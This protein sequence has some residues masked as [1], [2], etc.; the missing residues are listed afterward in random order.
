MTTIDVEPDRTA[1][2]VTEPHVRN[3]VAIIVSRFPRIDETFILREIN[4]LE[5]QGQPVVL[6]PLLR[7]A[8]SVVHEEA[9]PWVQRAMYLPLLSTAIVASNIRQLFRYPV[10]Y[11]RL[12][13]GLIF[14][15]IFNPGILLRTLAL[16]PKSV[17]LAWIFPRLGIKHIHAHFATH[18]TT[19]AYIVSKLTDVTYSFT[20]H[21]PDI[22]VH[23]LLLRKKITG[24]KF[25]RAVSTFNKAFM[26]GL[27]PLVAEDKVEVVHMG[28]NADV[29]SDAAAEAPRQKPRPQ[30][31]SVA[32]LAPSKGFPFLIDAIARLAKQGVDV[33]CRIVGDGPLRHVTER[34]I[35]QHGLESSVRLQGLLRQHEVARLMG[36]C[37]VFMLPSIIAENG[38]MDG[39]PVSLMEAMAAGRP[40]IASALSGIPELVDNEI[41]GLLVDATHPERIA[42]AI[43]RLV[44]DPELRDRMGRAGQRKVRE[45]FDIRRTTSSLMELFERHEEAA[46]EAPESLARLNWRELDVMALGIR[47]LRERRSS[48]IAEVTTTDGVKKRDVVVKQQKRVSADPTA[49]ISRARDEYEVLSRLREQLELSSLEATSDILYTVP[50]VIMFDRRNASLIMERASGI[51]LEALVRDAR[52]RNKPARLMGPLRRA[53]SW[54][55]QMED[56]TRR[57]EDGR[58]ILAHRLD[59]AIAELDRAAIRDGRIRRAHEAIGETIHSLAARLAEKPMV[60]VGHHGEFAPINVFI[61]DR[62]VEV[63]DFDRYRDGLPYEDA[64]YFIVR[65]QMYF[66]YPFVRHSIANLT[67]SF[68]NGYAGSAAAVDRDAL[69]LYS[70]ITGLELLTLHDDEDEVLKSWWHRRALRE[71]VTG[72]R[73]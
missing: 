67:E 68:L 38:N 28:V 26:L 2:D 12:L 73:P 36:E 11:L 35:A 39:I 46:M 50:R 61:G 47:R 31:L 33:E 41:N 55:R 3:A 60:T 56:A 34:W 17:Y 49:A 72:T 29:Y 57:D 13:F 58:T 4:E 52:N 7:E 62:R 1:V 25:I 30:V 44:N 64:A 16:F 21:G 69:K 45:H 10:R 32:A 9:K 18:A 15:A 14:G 20:T 42:A 59:Q 71:I 37:D 19:M 24:A 27:Y 40:V 22:F 53:G 65:L 48:R 5:R 6:V 54:L 23:R 8:A 43:L 66:S 63:I 70:I 51:P